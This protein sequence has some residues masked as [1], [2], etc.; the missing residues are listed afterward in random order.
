MRDK[1]S[2]VFQRRHALGAADTPGTTSRRYEALRMAPTVFHGSKDT[3]SSRVT[4]RDDACR[5]QK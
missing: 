5:Q 4:G 2:I 1:N 3:Q